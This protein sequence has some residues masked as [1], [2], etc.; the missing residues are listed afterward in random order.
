MKSRA[1]TLL[2]LCLL[3]VTACGTVNP[4]GVDTH[5]RIIPIYNQ[6]F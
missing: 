3:A 6:K 5:D 2:I 1:V 4:H